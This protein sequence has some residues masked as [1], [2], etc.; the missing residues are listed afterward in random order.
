MATQQNDRKTKFLNELVAQIQNEQYHF[1]ME[2]FTTSWADEHPSLPVTCDT[3][4]CI[5]GHI[6][7]LRPESGISGGSHAGR[8]AAIYR[9]ETGE[10]CRLDFYGINY[11][12]ADGFHAG[13]KYI[14]REEAVAHILGESEN[15]P[16]LGLDHEEF[17]H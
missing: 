10:Q 14:T 2:Y 1:D 4:S 6:E 12:D 11:R 5:A 17:P 3:A 16:Q 8:A 13:L 7:A 9:H 15:W